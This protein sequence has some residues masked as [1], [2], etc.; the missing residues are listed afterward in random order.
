[1]SLKSGG[2]P[3]SGSIVIERLSARASGLRRGDHIYFD[4]S[5][6]IQSLEIAGVIRHPFIKPPP[7]GGQLHFFADPSSAPLFGITKESFRQV[8]VQVKDPYS[9]EKARQVA[10]EIRSTLGR[11]G[12]GVNAALLQDPER[13]WGRHFLAGV[14]LV[15]RVLAWA[16]LALG[17]V[18]VLNTVSALITQ[19]VDQI[20]I[21]K[22]LGARRRLIAQV[23]L[24]E[25]LIVAAIAIAMAIPASLA[26]AYASSRWLVDLFNI[27]FTSFRYSARALTYMAIG[28]L[29]APLLAASWPILKGA[30]MSVREALASY[31][32]GADFGSSRFDIWIERIG[33]RWLPTLYAAAL[34][35]LFRRKARLLWTQGVMVIAG[36]MF[37]VVISLIASVNQ[38]LDNEMARST[39]D[40]RVGFVKEQPAARI[41]KL[42]RDVPGTR[43]VELWHRL[44]TEMSS[45][46]RAVHQTGSLGA[47][48][49]ALPVDTRMY[50]PLVVKGRWFDKRDKGKHVIVLSAETAELNG[51]KV[52]ASLSLNLGILG[53]TEWTV[54]G[55][56][57][58]LVGTDYTV[59]SVYVPLD[60]VQRVADRNHTASLAIIGAKVNSLA[61]ETAYADALK[62]K[63]EDSGVKLDFY[64]TVSRLE[65]RQYARN[66]FSPVTIMLLGLALLSAAVGGIGLSGTLAIGV[67][68]RLREIGVLRSIGAR[69]PVIF[70]LFMLEGLFHGVIAW[71]VSVP[72]AYIIAEP[73]SRRLGL[74]MLKIELD[75]VFHVPAIFL[76]LGIVLGLA[77]SAAYWPARNA[78]RIPVHASLTYGN[79]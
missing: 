54:I 2:W 24:S 27:D 57:R 44:P 65:Q 30:S 48:V 26:C 73:L 15:L 42:A 25:V 75:Y 74:T 10:R 63:F 50:R 64:T 4:T 36:V 23:Y 61:E 22:S 53:N 72:L 52:G 7:F 6:G 12:I 56:Y 45:G 33:A 68:Q 19:Q 21:M 16:A 20:G 37:L 39:Y 9:A 29:L 66:Q 71:L 5:A 59:E 41:A 32:L 47:Q 46:G 14:N 69:S 55:T 60:T 17:S 67:L 18:L 11:L 76:W 51:I 34:G 70:R 49:V 79:L 3:R 13:H 8:L 31:G 1:M 40:L 77:A 78:T 28:G 38:T 35:N 58:W 43:V 62:Q